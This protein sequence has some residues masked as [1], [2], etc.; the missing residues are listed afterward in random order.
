MELSGKESKTEETATAY[1]NL[2][3]L[4]NNRGNMDKAKEMYNK[5]LAINEVLGI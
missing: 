5:S 1:G 4:Y 2:G 3:N